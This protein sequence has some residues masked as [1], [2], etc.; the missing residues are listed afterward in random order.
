MPAPG[1]WSLGPAEVT[2]DA[3]AKE[4][5]RRRLRRLRGEVGRIRE[6][7]P[8]LQETLRELSV[9]E[10]QRRL[11]AD[12]AQRVTTLRR[13]CEALRLELKLFREEFEQLRASA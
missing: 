8:R 9:V 6:E 1:A 2:K 4:V 3:S 7:L 10:S 13:Q 12:E 5:R 11:G